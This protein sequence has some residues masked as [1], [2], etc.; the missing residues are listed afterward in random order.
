MDLS[1][2]L[3]AV[4]NGML[5]AVRSDIPI[6][7]TTSRYIIEAGGKRIR[8]RVMALSYLA[9][10]GSDIDEVIPVAAALELIHTASLIHDDINDQG[11]FRRGRET[12]NSH[13]GISYA[14]LTGDYLFTRV[15]Q[16]MAHY[17]A[18]NRILADATVTLVEGEALQATESGRASLRGETYLQIISK[19]TAS[20]F[21]A[22][23]LLGG[24]LAN[25][26]DEVMQLLSDYGQNLGLVFQITDDILDV[27]GDPEKLGKGVGVDIKQGKG[28][29][30]VVSEG[31]SSPDSMSG[32]PYS[33]S[34]NSEIIWQALQDAKRFGAEAQKGLERLPGQIYSIELRNIVEEI[35]LR[36]K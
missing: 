6:L 34:R 7:Q 32:I 26:N 9:A 28:V 27:I 15:Y 35:L 1:N 19:K 10:G 5:D 16:I 3:M 14:L 22:A 8:P 24:R 21:K 25:G 30:A 12:I 4:E 23:S 20:L 2:F 36:S 33:S 11:E 13:W 31:S 18:L 17:P 29:L